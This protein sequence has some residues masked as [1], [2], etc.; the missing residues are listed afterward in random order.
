MKR[1]FW[2]LI[3]ML[4]FYSIGLGLIELLLGQGAV[5]HFF[6]DITSPKN[7]SVMFYAINTTLTVFL[8]WATALL[9]II[10]C[11]VDSGVLKKERFFFVSQSVIFFVLGVDDRF[12][13][14]EQIGQKTGIE[15]AFI[16]LAIGVMELGFLF[17]LGRELLRKPAILFPLLFGGGFFFI[18][19]VIDA[20]VPSRTPLRLS[21]ED[22]T[23]L[24]A[25]FCLFLYGWNTL[26]L[27]LKRS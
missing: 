25:C 19:V 11:V 6:T 7:P 15:D 10:R 24:W 16:L 13:I 12:L 4:F 8:L 1:F 23:K 5:R 20:F 3:A 14:H 26:I 27:Y 9:F 2:F 21:A 18:M 17:T 22:L